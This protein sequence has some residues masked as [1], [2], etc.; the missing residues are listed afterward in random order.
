MSRCEAEATGNIL[1]ASH[2]VNPPAAKKRTY[3]RQG[4][5]LQK[6]FFYQ[7]CTNHSNITC[8]LLLSRPT[9][10]EW[11]EIQNGPRSSLP[12]ESRP[13]RGEWVEIKIAANA[14]G[15][16]KVSPHAGRVG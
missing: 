3:N 11:V 14:V 8:T 2:W 16:D 10:G 9:R 12:P 5:A 15:Y 13:T 6:V 1:Y 4:K 7:K